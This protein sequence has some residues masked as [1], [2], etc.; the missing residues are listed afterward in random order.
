MFVWVRR[1]L[2]VEVD[3]FLLVGIPSPL[4]SCWNHQG[5]SHIFILQLGGASGGKSQKKYHIPLKNLLL[6]SLHSICISWVVTI[7]FSYQALAL[8]TSALVK[9][10]F[11]VLTSPSSFQG[12]HLPYDHCC[13]M[14]LRSLWFSLY[15]IFTWS[16][17]GS[18]MSE[19]RHNLLKFKINFRIYFRV[20]LRIGLFQICHSS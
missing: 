15:S 4:N 18:D 7:Y 20:D 10:W 9:L 8:E 2:E 3:I 12:I 14:D 6:M 5:F 11:F 1:C 16:E 19:T 17:G 13:L